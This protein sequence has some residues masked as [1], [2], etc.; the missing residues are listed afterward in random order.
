MK[1]YTLFYDDVMPELPGAPLDLVLY[2][3]KK[4]CADFYTQSACGREH[5]VAFDTVANQPTYLVNTTDGVNFEF[6]QVISVKY[7]GVPLLP[8]SP[9]VL[10][11]ED[12]KWR[13]QTGRIVSYTME[14]FNHV[15]LVKVPDTAE[16]GAIA[17]EISRSPIATGGGIDDE[18]YRLYNDDIAAGV[19]AR[20]MRISRKPYS[21]AGQARD[22]LRD[23]NN[24]VGS[25][26]AW[27]EKGA[28][29]GPMRTRSYG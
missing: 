6:G 18:I 26:S 24:A 3:I 19:K 21:N 22:Y 12:F 28:G 16:V 14:D 20:L 25:A 27:A 1:A 11:R 5:L 7:N 8:K 2:H 23:Y 10:D 9:M 13:E 15:R 29:A 17:V 4:A